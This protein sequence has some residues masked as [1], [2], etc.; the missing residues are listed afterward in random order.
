M[1][2]VK[3]LMENLELGGGIAHPL[4]K[5]LSRPHVEHLHSFMMG[6]KVAV[7]SWQ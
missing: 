3:G 1:G 2:K 7:N 5:L 6:Q 4:Q